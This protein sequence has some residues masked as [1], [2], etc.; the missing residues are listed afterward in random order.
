MSRQAKQNVD[1]SAQH[2]LQEF[3]KVNAPTSAVAN[4]LSEIHDVH[5][6]TRDVINRANKIKL[7]CETDRQNIEVFFESIKKGG[8]K[9]L[10]KYH[11]GN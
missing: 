5:F 10:A 3:K 2:L 7:A 6:S 8:G 9:V 4:R 11:P 1:S